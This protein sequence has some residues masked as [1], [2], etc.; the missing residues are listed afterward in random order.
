VGWTHPQLAGSSWALASPWSPSLQLQDMI[1]RV[2]ERR[3]TYNNTAAVARSPL[4]SN[5][6]VLYVVVALW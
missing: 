2:F 3:P 5:L 6:K 1:N 4:F